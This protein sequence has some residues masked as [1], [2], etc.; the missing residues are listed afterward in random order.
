MAYSVQV[1][2]ADIPRSIEISIKLKATIN[3]MEQ[4]LT[5]TVGFSR[6]T[7][8]A[9]LLRS[10]ASRGMLNLNTFCHAFVCQ[11][12]FQLVKV[13]LVGFSL[14]LF[15]SL[16]LSDSF[17]V[18]QDNSRTAWSR[19][20]DLLGNQ[21]ID[22]SA[23][24]S[25]F[26]T[27]FAKVSFARMPFGLQFRSE[28]FVSLGNSFD[29]LTTEKLVLGSHCQLV[30]ASIDP[31]GFAAGW[32]IFNFFLENNVEKYFVISDEQFRSRPSPAQ[33]LFEV[34]R[35]D[36]FEF[37]S[38]VNRLDRDLTTIR[39]QSITVGI[40]TDGT[41]FGLRTGGISSVSDFRSDSLQGFGGFGS[42]GDRQLRRQTKVLSGGFVGFVVQ[43]NTIGV[44]VVPTSLTDQV[45]CLSVSSQSGTER[46]SRSVQDYFGCANQ[47]HIF[48]WFSES[49][50]T[51][52]F[53]FEGGQ[54]FLPDAKDVGVSLL[55]RV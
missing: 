42:C 9:T 14:L 23:K 32:D 11:K 39:H 8:Y 22:I 24:P 36:G 27:D 3:A 52:C 51:S 33:I 53:Y 10:I 15:P 37:Q 18:F 49:Q 45:V 19:S 38:S 55:C 41:T 17:Q 43:G 46:R 20:D 40:I 4:R 29:G 26:R 6:M 5:S 1:V 12:L 47:F 16:G 7:A 25:L 31:N 50:S 2:V 34:I 48:N 28:R 54:Q 44:L 35:E 13:P 30:D 21:V